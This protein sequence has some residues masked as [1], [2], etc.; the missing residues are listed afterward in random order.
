MI[1]FE[2]IESVDASYSFEILLFDCIGDAIFFLNDVV[3][4]YYV[5]FEKL[6][7]NYFVS[8]LPYSALQIHML[9]LFVGCESLRL[10]QQL[11]SCETVSSSNHSY[12]WASLTKLTA[13]HQY[14]FFVHILSLVTDN[15]PS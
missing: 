3:L 13:L 8:G 14:Q 10:S 9:L 11:W 5:V 1:L 6:F 12:S 15:N 2:N 4:Y 7:F